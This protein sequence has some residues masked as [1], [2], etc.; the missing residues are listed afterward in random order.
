MT[1]LMFDGCH[2][3]CLLDMGEHG[4]IEIQI[5]LSPGSELA[6]PHGLKDIRVGRN[7]SFFF[8][9]SSPSIA[10]NIFCTFPLLKNS[11]NS[12]SFILINPSF[13]TTSF[14]LSRPFY[15]QPK[16]KS[17]MKTFTAALVLSNRKSFP[18]PTLTLELF[19]N[20]IFHQSPSS[21]PVKE[22]NS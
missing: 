4:G 19:A 16:K 14:Q 22:P 3:Q 12:L 20:K 21:W 6:T 1:D 10:T 7:S 13:E 8:H 15:K 2:L 9:Q 11:G 17:K 5:V 18:S